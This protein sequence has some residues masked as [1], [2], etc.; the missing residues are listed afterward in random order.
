M[1]EK[2][3]KILLHGNRETAYFHAET[4]KRNPQT[5]KMAERGYVV[6]LALHVSRK[7]GAKSL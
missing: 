3:K 7:R 6:T 2:V 1:K 5:G 4:P